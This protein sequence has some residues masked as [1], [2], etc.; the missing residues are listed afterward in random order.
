[1]PLR[2]RP[3][4]LLFTALVMVVLALLGFTNLSHS[5]PLNDKMLH[6][7]CLM[8][9]TGV[10]Y[11][12]FDVEEDARRIWFWHHS[13]LIFTGTM[14][15]LFGGIVSEF[16]QSM[17]PYKEFQIGDVFANL[18]GSSV[19]LYVAYYLEK[20]YRHR[21][22]ISRLYRPLNAEDDLSDEEDL[23][24]GTQLLPTPV[25]PVATRDAAKGPAKTSR[26]QDVWDEGEELFD[27]GAESEEEGE[28]SYSRES[29][30][31]AH[32]SDGPR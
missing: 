27:I 3:W 4:F 31:I 26:L 10:F 19:G 23:E 17:L 21:R 2:F 30:P 14:C 9:A 32:L 20:Y 6:F 11:F 7:F 29:P 12:I 28:T 1:M 15:F 13:P 16:V 22:E 18:L 24:A 25:D 5:L 8:L